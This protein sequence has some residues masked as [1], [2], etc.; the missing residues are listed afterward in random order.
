[1]KKYSFLSLVFLLLF[2]VACKKTTTDLPEI[3]KISLNTEF[4]LDF[5]AV[6][7]IEN[8]ALRISFEEV[9]EDSRC[10]IDAICIWEGRAWVKLVGTDVDVKTDIELITKNSINLDSMVT[11]NYL[12]Y[13]IEL[14]NVDPYPDGSV[15]G[16]EEYSVTFVVTE[17]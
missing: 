10:P 6:G 13:Q 7:E 1:M 17:L 11:A 2:T 14:I 5:G 12:D 8:T 9:I 15:T 4:D 16:N 3:P